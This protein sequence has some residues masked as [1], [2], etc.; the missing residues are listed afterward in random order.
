MI[1][2]E[3]QEKIANIICEKPVEITCEECYLLDE[4]EICKGYKLS[5]VELL[6]KRKNSLS[7]C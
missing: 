4:G 1:K 3:C 7:M 2:K 5:N 6:K